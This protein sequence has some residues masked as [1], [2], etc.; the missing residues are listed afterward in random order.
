MPSL[1]ELEEKKKALQLERE[2]AWMQREK[3]GVSFAGQAWHWLLRVGLPVGLLLA[4]VA[5]IYNGM[6][7][8]YDKEPQILFGLVLV[9]AAVGLRKFTK[10]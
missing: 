10:P 8:S 7:K 9:V 4:G 3:A 2:I 1:N 6:E 5:N